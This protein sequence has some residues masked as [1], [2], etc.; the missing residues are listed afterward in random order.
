MGGASSQSSH[1]GQPG[2]A[3]RPVSVGFGAITQSPVPV[4]AP[5]FDSAACNN[6]TCMDIAGGDAGVADA[7]CGS[8]FG[9]DAPEAP[10]GV[11]VSQGD[12]GAVEAS[13]TH[14]D[15]AGELAS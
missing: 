14:V 15:V 2:H 8:G 5:A 7:G 11:G 4:V 1:A 13:D 3:H 12:G 6:R 10:A 9:A